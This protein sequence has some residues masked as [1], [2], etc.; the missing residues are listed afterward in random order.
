MSMMYLLIVTIILLFI[1][2]ILI[3]K[4]KKKSKINKEITCQE[5]GTKLST[6]NKTC[7]KC[8]CPIKRNKKLLIYSLIGITL[9][10]IIIILSILLINNYKEKKYIDNQTNQRDSSLA[11]IEII[12]DYINIRENKNTNSTIIGK[13]YKGEI[14]TIIS[15]DKESSYN[16]YEIQTNNNLKGFIA[17]K[18]NDVNYVKILEIDNNN[19]ENNSEENNVNNE[20]SKPNEENTN[21]NT[22]PNNNSNNTK[23]NN[24]NSNNT[25]KPNN[26]TENN[27]NNNSQNNY[28]PKLDKCLKTCG[29]GYILKNQDSIECYCEQIP[30]EKT[31]NEKLIAV[32]K[33]EG[34]SCT[35]V[36]CMK[37]N[38]EYVGTTLNYS[39]TFSINFYY[40]KVSWVYAYYNGSGNGKAEIYYGNN[41]GTSDYYGAGTNPSH[42]QTTCNQVFPTL[43]CNTA[44][45]SATRPINQAIDK[46]N[47][48]LTKANI[49]IDDLKNSK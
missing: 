47:N 21:N 42:Y 25:N 24:N 32:L 39:E 23:P 40:K 3:I 22:K 30:V 43:S 2:V 18:N 26:N 4:T 11:Q 34:Y 19:L 41:S 20:Q 17:G 5:C 31:A 10:I 14:Y 38:N 7:P 1:F 27:N 8:G 15:E 37:S 49:S 35:S 12:T 13:V 28:E 16:W 29:E 46:L 44:P 6:S 33:Q 36:Q 45:S 48:L 9:L